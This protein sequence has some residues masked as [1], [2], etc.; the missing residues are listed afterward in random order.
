MTLFIVDITYFRT[1]T[2]RYLHSC[3]NSICLKQQSLPVTHSCL[4][5]VLEQQKNYFNSV[6]SHLRILTSAGEYLITQK[7]N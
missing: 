4:H 2:G 6:L 1:V 3:K 7:Y 5:C